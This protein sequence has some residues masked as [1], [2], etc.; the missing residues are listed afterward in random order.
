MKKIL[1]LI[2]IFTFI[3]VF[4][5]IYSYSVK[6]SSE[7][8]V[9]FNTR[10]SGKELIKEQLIEDDGSIKIDEFLLDNPFLITGS[11]SKLKNEI[12]ELKRVANLESFYDTNLLSENDSLVLVGE[13]YTNLL[14]LLLELNGYTPINVTQEYPG[15]GIGVIEFLIKEVKDIYGKNKPMNILILSGSDREGTIN[16]MNYFKKLISNG[17]YL[18]YG[19]TF[20]NSD[21]KEVDIPLKVVSFD[22]KNIEN[23]L[24]EFLSIL[25]IKNEELEHKSEYLNERV[26]MYEEKVFEDRSDLE[27]FRDAFLRFDLH[28]PSYY[29]KGIF[30][31][32]SDMGDVNLCETAL[33]TYGGRT[34]NEDSTYVK[35]INDRVRHTGSMFGRKNYPWN[36]KTFYT[37]RKENAHEMFLFDKYFGK[38]TGDCYAQAIFN[39][40]VFRLWGFDPER[41][42]ILLISGDKG[43]HAVNLLNVGNGWF[44]FD[45]TNYS[46]PIWR[47]NYSDYFKYL[48]GFFSE[49]SYTLFS[50]YFCRYNSKS[51]FSLQDIKKIALDV[52]KLFKGN[53]VF[54]SKADHRE[55]IED[56]IPFTKF[57]NL[58][59]EP[60]NTTIFDVIPEIPDSIETTFNWRIYSIYEILS[61]IYNEREKLLKNTATYLSLLTYTE[62]LEKSIDYPES[63]YTLSRYATQT[64]RVKNPEVYAMGAII[65]PRTAEKA[66]EAEI[67][68]SVSEIIDFVRESLAEIR[69]VNNGSTIV[70]Y[71]DMTL[72][73]KEGNQY[74]KSL[75]AYALAYHLL[76]DE[77]R[78]N[79]KILWGI[80]SGF[81]KYKLGEEYMYLNCLSGDIV[82]E[83]PNNIWVEFNI[84]SHKFFNLPPYIPTPVKHLGK[85]YEKHTFSFLVEDFN[86]KNTEKI[87][88]C[89]S[90]KLIIT[91]EKFNDYSKYIKVT[92]D[93]AKFEEGLHKIPI[94]VT[95]TYGFSEI[96]FEFEVAKSRDFIPPFIT[97]DQPIPLFIKSSY[98]DI[99]FNVEDN[100]SS[101]DKIKCLFK[102]DDKGWFEVSGFCVHLD[103][104]SE[105]KHIF[106]MKSI[107]EAG[108]ESE[109][110]KIEFTVDF[111]PPKLLI[112]A[113]SR[114]YD[115][116][117]LTVIG[118]VEDNLSGVRCV[119]LNKN[120]IM[121]VNKYGTFVSPPIPLSLGPNTIAIEVIDKAGN[122]NE[123]EFIVENIHRTILKLQIGNKVMLVN[124]EPVKIDVPPTIVEGRTLLPIRWVAEPL[125]ATVGWDGTE[126][127]VTVSLGDV[128]IEL[129]IGK[130]IA[131]VNGVE[132]PIDPNNPKVVPMIIKGRTMLP[133]RFVA[134]NLGADVLWDGATKTVT[135]IYPGD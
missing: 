104:L 93:P 18:K 101:P 99:T 49:S 65:A 111:T 126:R 1:I 53:L 105:G 20:I 70:E 61:S 132:K 23:Y 100:L 45:S 128:F 35:F 14:I 48:T 60:L 133:V 9:N 78:E 117:S 26:R 17:E 80:D 22:Y 52:R 97:I 62:V 11:F 130:N 90:D 107:D 36:S 39:E 33:K 58:A 59:D 127:K 28:Y 119:K 31:T 91:P 116:P 38:I 118:S 57:D 8:T 92:I 13:N 86:W 112:N 122:M 134:E 124:D 71:P 114:V 46:N 51:N 88:S 50:E 5:S 2:I 3:P 89:D 37:F 76:E 10:L 6:R 68:N 131:R 29:P 82:S 123:I 72:F 95:N 129:W 125:G 102:L 34:L 15:R 83:R 120:K 135:I 25:E 43:G 4:V 110:I 41:T 47:N 73:I 42:F 81:L 12:K 98:L 7:N 109:P 27:E 94:E 55:K 30:T 66:N 63:Q 24:S 40:A 75:L 79:L 19:V 69:S 103:N 56:F 85:I 113:A 16:A 74:S 84:N 77:D 87:I 115:E 21:L 64:V 108:N 106:L 44:L 121:Y 67:N 32:I 96:T 54:G